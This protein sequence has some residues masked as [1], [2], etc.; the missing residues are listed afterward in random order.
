MQV[1]SKNTPLQ[2]CSPAPTNEADMNQGP[3]ESKL[4]EEQQITA[5][6]MLSTAAAVMTPPVNVSHR[7]S[8]ICIGQH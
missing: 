4:T 8:F 7:M 3:A 2:S 5:A 6:R 1:F